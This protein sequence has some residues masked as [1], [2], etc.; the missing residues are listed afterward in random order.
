MWPASASNTSEFD[1][2]AAPSSNAMKATRRTSDTR[3]ARRSVS[4]V[5]SPDPLTWPSP[6][7]S[8]VVSVCDHF[9]DEAADVRVVDDIEDASPLA[10]AP[11][12]P[13]QA[14]LGEMLRHRRRLGT[15]H[16]GQLVHRVFPLE[17]GPDHPQPRLVAQ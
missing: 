1:A 4:A 8:V 13:R 7:S 17:E 9:F 6:M 12:Q 2:S 3:S 15:H 16:V 5:A 10:T 14:Q 11:Y